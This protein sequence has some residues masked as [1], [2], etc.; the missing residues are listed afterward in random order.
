IVG[1]ELECPAVEFQGL[2]T[3][4]ELFQQVRL[5]SIGH[6]TPPGKSEGRD[7]SQG[8]DAEATGCQ[9]QKPL[10]T[11]GRAARVRRRRLWRYLW[12]RR[13]QRA[14]RAIPLYPSLQCQASVSLSTPSSCQSMCID[15]GRHMHG[16][17][18]CIDWS[19][20]QVKGG[21]AV[22]YITGPE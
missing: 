19:K 15:S 10:T 17:G 14:G 12:C 2:L 22:V 9:A 18:S 7:Q 4:T 5:I 11:P 21:V 8:E 6:R 3:S 20:W 13:G 1:V 16:S